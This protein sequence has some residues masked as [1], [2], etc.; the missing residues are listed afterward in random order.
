MECGCPVCN[1]IIVPERLCPDCGEKMKD[2]GKIEDY[3]GPYSPYD[4]ED[5]YENPEL[6]ELAEEGQCVH[7]YS[8]QE[9]GY[10]ERVWFR[11]VVM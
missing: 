7:L 5:L 11:S 2:T 1:G 9:C 6:W 3:Y 8:C 4:N 10:D